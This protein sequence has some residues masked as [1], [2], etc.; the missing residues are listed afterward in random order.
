MTSLTN[1][2][3][4]YAL[5]RYLSAT[6]IPRSLALTC[7]GGIDVSISVKHISTFFLYLLKHGRF[8]GYVYIYQ[9]VLP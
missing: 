7:F 9:S 1:I 2:Y 4:S 8:L 5:L 6:P 3:P